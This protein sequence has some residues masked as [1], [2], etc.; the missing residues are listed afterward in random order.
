[1]LAVHPES[2][3]GSVLEDTS[4]GRSDAPAYIDQQ[5]EH[6]L[7]SV[8]ARAS[9]IAQG[10][11]GM[12]LR[13]G[14]RIGLLALNQIEWL[15]VFF[16]AAKIGVGVVALSVR[17]RD[18]ELQYM[19][20]DSGAKALFTTRQHEGFDFVQM[21]ERL[22]PV[23]PELQHVVV[24]DAAGPD[25]AQRTLESL[26]TAPGNSVRLQAAQAEVQPGDLAM[27]IYTSGTTGQPKGAG[28][29]HASLLA[30]AS[31]QARH[32][33]ASPDDMMQLA[34]PL[35]H[36]GGITCGVLTHLLGGGVCE[37]VP[38]F[39]ADLMLDLMARRAPT[40][41]TGVPTML[42]LML[43]SPASR[44]I[45]LGSVRLIITGGSNVEQ[46]L[47]M[48]LR[49]RMPQAA[50]MNL[51]GLSESSGA[52]VMTPWAC[53]EEELMT[54]IGQAFPE[55]EV[56]V[57]GAEGLDATG[58][59]VGELLFRGAGVVP[60]YIGAAARSEAVDAQGWLHTGDLGRMDEAG[61]IRLMGRKKDMYIQG[62]FNVYPAEIENF[63]S[64][65]PAVMMVAGIG[66]KDPVLGEVGRYYVVAKPGVAV[67][68][69]EIRAYCKQHLADYKVPRQIVLR[70]ELPLTP[71][72]KIHKAALR[73]ET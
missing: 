5:G 17:Y 46:A 53:S 67:T 37:L 15:Q 71:A 72:G 22:A 30:S 6:S 62:G 34:L 73:T 28:L 12:G 66:I 20:A 45:D 50:I 64:Q 56:R 4:R 8:D 23:L 29:T 61:F 40:I 63:I 44:D 43:M 2:T 38:V 48:Q 65:H 3:L 21:L 39:K 55:A 54:S 36:V 9:Q 19:L 35:N 57:L 59:E 11:L 26:I 25:G 51:Y 52:I 31:A 24:L 41:L 1:M 27:V 14:D 7:K 68:E 18:T 13:R 49:Q 47:L 42:T 60:G 33:K 32:I 69:D 10:L 16:A 70:S 58:D